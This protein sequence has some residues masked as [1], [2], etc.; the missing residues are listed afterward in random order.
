MRIRQKIYKHI[1]VFGVGFY[2]V[3]MF[4]SQRQNVF[5][6]NIATSVTVGNSSPTFSAGPAESPATD[7]TSPVNVGSVV[8]FSATA[9]DSNNENYYLAVCRTNA[10]NSVNGG[11]PTCNGGAGNTFCVSNS[12]TSGSPT[13]CTYT[14]AIGDSESTSWY[15]FVCDGNSVSASCSVSSQGSGVSGS[16][17]FVNHAP[18]FTSVGVTTPASVGDTISW[19]TGVGTSD[20]DTQ[21]GADTVKLVVCKTSGVVN[22]DCDGGASDRWC[23]SGPVA[24]SPSCAYAVSSP[25]DSGTY[26]AYAYI[27]DS[28]NLGSVS[29]NQGSSKNFVVNNAIPIISTISI[30]GGSNI[31]LQEGVGATTPITISASI[32]D[33][34]GCAD[35]GSNVLA[36]LYRSG[37]AYTNCNASGKANNNNCYPEVSCSTSNCASGSSADFTCIVQMK[38][39]S[40]PTDVGSSFATQNWLASFKA[41]D[42]LSGIGTTEIG[43]GVELI[44]QPALD[45]TPA[46]IAY[47]NLSAGQKNDPLS[48]AT[49]ITATGNT[50]INEDLSGNDMTDG[51]G[52]TIAIANQKYSL[53]N[54]S[55]YDSGTSLSTS[56]IEV[57]ILIPKVTSDIGNTKTTYW[58][59]SVPAGTV[60]GTYSGENVI[61]AVISPLNNW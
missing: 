18:F 51:S 19:T 35:V 20:T 29:G 4:I 44:S 17:L 31:N 49:V 28:H 21:G 61:N 16:P 11:A 40:D 36:Y 7:N 37:V 23:Q 56:A 30:N 12:T 41:T 1:S 59:L 57:N 53:N 27:L 9:A 43:S 48:V 14:A 3:L 47:G 38:S 2:L 6:K 33:A 26:D 39:Y 34:N 22:G 50:G 8:T 15:A 45:V 5:A 42:H 32:T 13:S 55:S 46:S 52:H 58:G 25:T 10:V 54:N 24:T 60:A